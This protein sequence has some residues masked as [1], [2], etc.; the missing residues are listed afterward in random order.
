MTD[1]LQSCIVDEPGPGWRRAPAPAVA[2][3]FMAMR[4]GSPVVVAHADKCELT[5]LGD[6]ATTAGVALLIRHG[7]GLITVAME[8]TRLQELSIP[9]MNSDYETRLP[10]AHVAVD[11]VD[12]GTG[13]SA[14]DRTTTIRRLSDP[15]STAESFT[16]PGHVIP[17]AADRDVLLGSAHIGLLLAR[18][19]GGQPA[20]AA[21]CALISSNPS[22]ATA[23]TNEGRAFADF[24]GLSFVEGQQITET[25]YRQLP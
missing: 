7:S 21:S 9:S 8:A 18:L 24:H 15:A 5:V 4:S 23:T 1:L 3:I 19:A 6:A 13:I 17:V 22:G 12:V 11:A 14:S 20:T 25:Y 2:C 16:R 10:Q